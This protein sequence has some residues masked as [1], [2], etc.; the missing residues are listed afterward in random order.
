MIQEIK[1][2]E[3]YMDGTCTN[4]VTYGIMY[5]LITNTMYFICV[6]GFFIYICI[7]LYK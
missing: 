3:N 2:T 5:K 4:K 6:W 7:Y 1:L